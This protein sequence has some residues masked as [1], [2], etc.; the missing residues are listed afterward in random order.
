MRNAFQ[1]FESVFYSSDYLT[2]MYKILYE[3]VKM[4]D[5]LSEIIKE[6]IDKYP[7]EMLP[8]VVADATSLLL[9]NYINQVGQD[10]LDAKQKDVI[11]E[12]ANLLDIELDQK[13]TEQT[14]RRPS[15]EEALRAFDNSSNLISKSGLKPDEVDELRR[16]PWWDNFQRWR[17]N[18][19]RGLLLTSDV[20]E[21]NLEEN[22]ALK[23]ILNQ[24]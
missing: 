7:I 4:G 10:L 1:E 21:C 3:K 14:Y 2:S 20:T 12:N 8:T 19:V 23:E 24:L 5:K 15:L 11:L 6:Y 22:S 13:N 18:L 17:D 16:L 9:N